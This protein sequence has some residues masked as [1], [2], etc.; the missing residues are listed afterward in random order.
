MNPA[1]AG[2]PWWFVI[3]FAVCAAAILA[4]FRVGFVERQTGGTD[5]EELG[6]IR[7]LVCAVA[8]FYVLVWEA[9][10]PATA[11]LPAELAEIG[12]LGFTDPLSR[13]LPGWDEM[14]RSEAALR[15]LKWSTALFL[16][17]GGLGVFARPA[18]LLAALGYFLIGGVT[19]SYSHLFHT[20]LVPL[21]LLVV[22]AEVPSGDGFTLGR[23]RPHLRSPRTAAVYGRARYTMWFVLALCY[24]MAGLSKLRF[25]GLGWASA[26]NLRSIVLRDNL[27]PM[28]YE[29][30]FGLRLLDAPDPVWWAMGV[31]TLIAEVGYFSVL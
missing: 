28:Q 13:L 26:Q 11:R 19:R 5:A 20:G 29:L 24:V 1:V 16:T 3:L 31:L 30:G 14:V 9:S 22:L 8:L 12:G 7:A 2:G 27:N 17:L 21:Y 6:R 15:A 18:L 25:G 4:A 10:F 23:R